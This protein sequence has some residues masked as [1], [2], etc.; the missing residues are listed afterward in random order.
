MSLL[1]DLHIS[2]TPY[3][4]A[5]LSQL[6]MNYQQG[7]GG[8]LTRMS[9]F[10]PYKTTTVWKRLNTFEWWHTFFINTWLSAN[11]PH[12]S[13]C[14]AL[15]LQTFPQAS[16]HHSTLSPLS[17]S[18]LLSFFMNIMNETTSSTHFLY[19]QFSFAVFIL[20]WA[21]TITDVR[22]NPPLPINS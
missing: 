7:K 18:A 5:A 9:V 2:M 12:S 15:H 10:H 17:H 3:R 19:M 8:A 14:F 16:P 20:R 11:N 6:C 21:S 1:N 4:D 22:L 13:H